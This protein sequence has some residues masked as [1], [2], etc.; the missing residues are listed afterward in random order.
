[1]PGHRHLFAGFVGVDLDVVIIHRVGGEQPEHGICGEPS[2]GNDFFQHGLS[3][4]KQLAGFLAHNLVLQDLRVTSGQF[5]C[6][7]ERRPVYVF[8]DLVERIGCE[9]V[10][11]HQP[12]SWR[13]VMFPVG[14]HSMR[15]GLRQRD[16][17][18][19]ALLSF[20]LLARLLVVRLDARDV[21]IVQRVAE[22]IAAYTHCTRR[23]VDIDRRPTRVIRFDLHRGVH[24][25]SGRAADQQRNLETLTFHLLCHVRHLFQ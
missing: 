9:F 16:M 20:M 2:F 1:M 6:L 7:E 4:G 21:F 17:L 10:H 25:R 14:F 8:G 19:F 15:T 18:R 24:A 22:Q 11:A 5:P 3:V 23:I 12:W 13:C